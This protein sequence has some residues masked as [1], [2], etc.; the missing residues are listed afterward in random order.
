MS[1][2]RTAPD[3]R[4]LDFAGLAKTEP[5]ASA[6]R[7]VAARLLVAALLIAAPAAARASL[8]D[9]R[10][11]RHLIAQL[12]AGTKTWRE[13]CAEDFDHVGAYAM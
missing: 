13:L 5:P 8:V 12:P 2:P 1:P 3:S 7:R 9:E 4:R 6:S 11:G 10:Q